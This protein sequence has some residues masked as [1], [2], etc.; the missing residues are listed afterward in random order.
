MLL[1]LFLQFLDPQPQSFNFSQCVGKCSDFTRPFI[2]TL[3]TSILTIVAREIVV[4][5]DAVY[6]A[7]VTS[8]GDLIAF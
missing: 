2:V 1:G 7:P 6:T 8:S 3:S 4:A 5:L